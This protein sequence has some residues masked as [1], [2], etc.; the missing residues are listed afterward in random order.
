MPRKPGACGTSS[1]REDSTNPNVVRSPPEPGKRCAP[2][3][4]ENDAS[5]IIARLSPAPGT[6]SD[7][8]PHG[9]DTRCTISRAKNTTP[10]FKASATSRS[11]SEDVRIVSRCGYGN[12]G[13][14]DG[15][16]SSTRSLHARPARISRC[17]LSNKDAWIVSI[18]VF[19]TTKAIRV[20][21]LWPPT[22]RRRPTGR[23]RTAVPHRF[24]P[25][26]RPRRNFAPHV[27]TRRVEV[28]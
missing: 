3:P 9:N 14:R 24:Q 6:L 26:L 17:A 13:P 12:P 21:P 20:I 1:L 2:G 22:C 18:P 15:S 28:I 4:R 11:D 27:R 7:P 5:R 10:P 16:G 23:W 19:L 8:S 25:K